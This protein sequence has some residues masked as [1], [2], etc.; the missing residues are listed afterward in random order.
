M[1]VID[2]FEENFA[3]VVMDD[4][5][6]LNIQKSKLPVDAKEGDVIVLSETIIIDYDETKR[7]KENTSKYLELW[8]D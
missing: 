3:V 4:G 5:R 7:R 8:E 2:R 6:I 1:G